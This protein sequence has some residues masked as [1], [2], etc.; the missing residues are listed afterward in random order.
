MQTNTNVV[1]TTPCHGAHTKLI[2]VRNSRQTAVRWRTE[3]A[4]Q[5]KELEER[6]IEVNLER[7]HEDVENIEESGDNI[8]PE[9]VDDQQGRPQNGGGWMEQGD[10][11]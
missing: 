11:W 10:L 2:Q 7:E 6:R 3:L 9:A 1:G 5:Q 4:A 8:E